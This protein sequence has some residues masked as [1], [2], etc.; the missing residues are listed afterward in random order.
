MQVRAQVLLSVVVADKLT[1]RSWLVGACRLLTVVVKLLLHT[2]PG[3]LIVSR[4]SPVIALVALTVVSVAPITSLVVVSI[5]CPAPRITLRLVYS[6][7]SA[8]A[9]LGFLVGGSEVNGPTIYVSFLHIMDQMLRYGLILK[10]N[11][12]KASTGIRVGFSHNLN[13][14]HDTV[15]SKISRQVI[16]I[17]MVIKTSNENFFFCAITLASSP[18]LL[19]LGSI[20]WRVPPLRLPIPRATATTSLLPVPSL[21][22]L[23]RNLLLRLTGKETIGGLITIAKSNFNVATSNRMAIFL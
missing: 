19:L 22:T 17:Q 14:L 6:L 9:S 15:L 16:L 10:G 12:T 11:E 18:L 21:L 5:I 3:I 8:V 20:T 7:I 4:L 2:T 1:E 13:F 23:V